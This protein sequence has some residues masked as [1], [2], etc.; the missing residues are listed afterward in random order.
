MAQTGL[1]QAKMG[2]SEDIKATTG[3]Y[4]ASLGMEGN[5]RSGKAILARQREGDT[6]TYHY[7]DNL[8]RAVRYVTRQLIDMI[9]KIYDTQRI[10]RI[11]GEDGE[12]DMVKIDPGQQEPVKEIRDQQGIVIE[13]IYNPSVGKYD[14]VVITGP[15]YATKRQEA[16]E[17]MAQLLQTAPELW[18]VAGDLF[19]KNMDWPGAEELAKR[20]AR[21]IDPKL[22]SDEDDPAL[23]AANQQIQAMAQ[24]ME[25]M[26]QMLKNVQAS[27]DNREL[28]VKEFDALTRRISAIEAGM[29]EQQIQDIVTGTLHAAIEAGDIGPG[30]SPP[31]TADQSVETTP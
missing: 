22:L 16:L 28:E 26:H 29:S 30:A 27:F 23:Q 18:Q 10:I 4:D 2:A 9:P 15:G 12:S 31:V 7:V 13:K 11:I 3:Q 19:V 21:T 8:A 17:A 20:L 14:V 5:E 1:I 24:E 25:Q 6:G